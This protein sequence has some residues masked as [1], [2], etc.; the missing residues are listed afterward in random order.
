MTSLN[1]KHLK[2]VITIVVAL[3][4]NASDA[5]SCTNKSNGKTP[6]LPSPRIIILGETGVGKSGVANILM[7]RHPRDDSDQIAEL[8]FESG[9][10]ASAWKTQG[11]VQT[12]DTCYDIGPWLG[13]D[14]N[15]KV[16]VIDTPGFGDE[17]KA[18][19][20]TIH[21]LV[22]VLKNKIKSVDVFVLAFKGSTNRMTAAM[23]DMLLLFQSIFGDEFWDNAIIE[24]THWSYNPSIAKKR[25]ETEQSFTDMINGILKEKLKI[26]KTL[27]SVFIDSY[28]FDD[29][30]E[31]V[32]AFEDNTKKLFDFAK[33]VN[34]FDVKG[35][36]AVK[37]ELTRKLEE[38]ENLKKQSNEL[39]DQ[40]K[41]KQCPTN[42]T[43]SPP[44]MSSPGHSTAAFVGFGMGMCLLG[45][46]VGVLISRVFKDSKHSDE[47]DVQTEDV[48]TDRSEN[49]YE[50]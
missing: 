17:V 37:T 10:F 42:S 6:N 19:D 49:G 26:T 3:Q 7:G 4:L 39:R 14:Q 33:G 44:K 8:C 20:R 11:T 5:K 1:L 23:S 28:Y 41:S 43:S 12:N 32:K 46:C 9:C 25:Q 38:I 24:V 18:E 29:K 15:E 45:I 16:T 40:I 22:D 27:D 31:E 50:S 30:V 48:Q 35:I 47:E 34:P 21:R 2:F 36:K 13:N